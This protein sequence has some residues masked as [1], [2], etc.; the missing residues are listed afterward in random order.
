MPNLLSFLPVPITVETPAGPVAIAPSGQTLNPTLNIGA[1][2]DV[3]LGFT[4]RVFRA[5]SDPEATYPPLELDGYDGIL[6]SERDA[7]NL[8]ILGVQL[9]YA[10]FMI[11]FSTTEDARAPFLCPHLMFGWGAAPAPTQGA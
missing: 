10:V 8:S 2:P 1:A 4:A 11:H 3:G 9:P 6:I 5:S 7:A